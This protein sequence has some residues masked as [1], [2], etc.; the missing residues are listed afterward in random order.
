MEGQ[1]S[2]PLS[3]KFLGSI[4]FLKRLPCSSHLILSPQISTDATPQIGP[5]KADLL[6][7]SRCPPY[8]ATAPSLVVFRVEPRAAERAMIEIRDE[9]SNDY[10][11]I[12]ELHERAF[13]GPA[14]ARLVDMLRAA[15][16]AAISLV[17]VHE[18]RVVGHIFFSPVTVAAVHENI[19]A[20]GLAPMSV[21]PEFQNRG[22]G[23]RLVHAGLGAC[24]R[25]GY[26]VVVVL[27]HTKYYPRFGFVRAKDKGLDNEYNANDSFMVMELEKGVLQ[28]IRGLVKYAPEFRAAKC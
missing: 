3:L 4:D 2:Q 17:A 24:K 11:A 16:K 14:E 8:H 20:V 21:L 28:G 1:L 26:E 9:A 19:R 15:N 27:G 25:K 22:I 10:P 18:N 7:P 13:G 12:R 5:R 6:V 23:S